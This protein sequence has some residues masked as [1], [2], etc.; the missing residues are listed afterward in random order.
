MTVDV[1]KFKTAFRVDGESEDDL[2]KGYLSAADSFVKNA[3]GTDDE[4]YKADKVQSLADV[5][6]LSLAGTYYQY[7][8][9]LSDVQVYQIDDT[10]NSIIGQLRGMYAQ[11]LN[12][13]EDS[14]A[15]EDTT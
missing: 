15:K 7:R 11:F 6:T 1:E 8:M 4:F 13:K 14:D 3:V 12:S 9:T 2:I 10:L 5:A